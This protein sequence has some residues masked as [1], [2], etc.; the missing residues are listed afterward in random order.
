MGRKRK[1]N[2]GK[3]SGLDNEINKQQKMQQR[4]QKNT[5]NKLNKKSKYIKK[6]SP[7]K[8]MCNQLLPLGL[9]LRDPRSDGNCLFRA[10]SDQLNGNEND[11]KQ[12]RKSIV[13]YM[14]VNHEDFAPFYIGDFD[15][16]LIKMGKDAEWGG[17]LELIAISKCY[18]VDII[19]HQLDAAKYEILYPFGNALRSIHLAYTE[20]RHYMSVR[21]I[22]DVGRGAAQEIILG[23]SSDNRIREL[24][25]KEIM[26]GH[27]GIKPDINTG[28]Y[29]KKMLNNNGKKKDKPYKG[30][31]LSK[32]ER[33]VMQAT[34]CMNIKHVRDVLEWNENNIDA[35]IEFL[36]NER[37]DFGTKIWDEIE[38]KNAPKNE[39]KTDTNQTNNNNNSNN[40]SKTDNN[41]DIKNKNSNN[42]NSIDNSEANEIDMDTLNAIIA[43]E[44]KKNPYMDNDLMN[45]INESMKSY[46]DKAKTS[47]NNNNKNNKYTQNSKQKPKIKVKIASNNNNNN[48]DSYNGNNRH[49]NGHNNGNKSTWSNHNKICECGSGL[50]VKKCCGKRA[51]YKGNK[52]NHHHYNE[53]NN[54]NDDDDPIEKLQKQVN[55][56][57]GKKKK[58][59]QAKLNALKNSKKK[60]EENVKRKQETISKQERQKNKISPLAHVTINI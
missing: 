24:K 60:F 7:F 23:N 2:K 59:L 22:N 26:L 38:M 35:A 30:I 54:N 9:E 11:H 51:N 4:Q 6:D 3:K 8:R 29:D 31:K 53:L 52:N 5:L 47:N 12:Y 58:K 18:K 55:C 17:N 20:G 48:R 36:V 16:Y 56:L 46:K 34:Q 15:K 57:K 14:K 43:C 19:I 39:P 32:N 28:R 33:I 50:K 37:T 49:K 21:Q 25:R 44:E 40:D 42:G 1:K 13:N 45:G 10:L 27:Q 41:S